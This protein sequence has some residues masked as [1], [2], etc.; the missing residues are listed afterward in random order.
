M[1]PP[2]LSFRCLRLNL[3]I[4]L[5]T[6]GLWPWLVFGGWSLLARAQEPTLFRQFGINIAQ[7]AIWSGSAILFLALALA[8]P[9]VYS[10]LRHA[11]ILSA[12]LVAGVGGIQAAVSL[13]L[14]FIFAATASPAAAARSAAIFCFVWLPAAVALVRAPGGRS[15]AACSLQ[16]GVTLVSLLLAGPIWRLDLATGAAIAALASLGSLLATL[17][18]AASAPGWARSQPAESHP[19]P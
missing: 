6:V 12:A 3:L 11:V 8:G 15:W 19:R 9:P 16:V 1:P 4:R 10:L 14:D 2:A 13:L 18:V 7:T 5:R 17:S